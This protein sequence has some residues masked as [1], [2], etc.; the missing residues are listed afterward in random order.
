MFEAPQW[1]FCWC[2]LPL[3]QAATLTE[4]PKGVINIHNDVW[5]SRCFLCNYPPFS[6]TPRGFMTSKRHHLAH[7]PGL[8]PFLQTFLSC[9]LF[10]AVKPCQNVVL[11][12]LCMMMMLK[13]FKLRYHRSKLQ[14][15]VFNRHPA[16]CRSFQWSFNRGTS[17]SLETW[18]SSL[19]YCV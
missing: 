8:L 10:F 3:T 11:R 4:Q 6:R 19:D 13:H 9:C 14:F 7:Y 15:V 5:P 1:S 2:R 17:M 18:I 16:N 12:S